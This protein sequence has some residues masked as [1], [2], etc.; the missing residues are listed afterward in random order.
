MSDEAD[1]SDE[2]SQQ[3]LDLQVRDIRN[4]SD[5]KIV[6]DGYCESCNSNVSPVQTI[7]R[8]RKA[9]VVGRWCSLECRDAADR[10]N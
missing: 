3:L 4:K 5:V 10:G 1:K 8:G 6:G 2:I 7:V 9:K